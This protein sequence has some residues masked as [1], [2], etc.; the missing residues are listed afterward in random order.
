MKSVVHS[1]PDCHKKS[2]RSAAQLVSELK[3]LAHCLFVSIYC[4][5]RIVKTF[6]ENVNAT[7]LLFEVWSAEVVE[8]E[9]DG[10][11]FLFRY[12]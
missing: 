1:R 4:F 5:N 12:Y 10:K 2:R 3:L 11:Q 8:L 7:G 9:N 6:Y